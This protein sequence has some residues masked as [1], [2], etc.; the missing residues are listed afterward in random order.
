MNWTSLS[1]ILKR[2]LLKDQKT[3]LTLKED[4]RKGGYYPLPP[5]MGLKQGSAVRRIS[6]ERLQDEIRHRYLDRDPQVKIKGNFIL[7]AQRPAILDVYCG[8][9]HFRAEGD[10]PDRAT[11]EGLTKESILKQLQ[12]T[13]DTPFVFDAA[14]IDP[15]EGLFLPVSSLN[16][17]RR[18]ALAGLQ[19]EIIAS[20]RRDTISAPVR[21]TAGE[22]TENLTIKDN[23]DRKPRRHVLLSDPSLLAFVLSFDDVD[24]ICLDTVYYLDHQER[25]PAGDIMAVK[26]AG[27]ECM[28]VMPWIWREKTQR[29][30]QKIFP[31]Q[32]TAL[33]D[34]YLIRLADQIPFC[35]EKA[36]RD[37]VILAADSS[38]YTW[39]TGAVRELSQLGLAEFTM[40]MELNHHEL[41]GLADKRSELVVYG[42]QKIM[43]T[44]QC[45]KKNTTACDGNP[46]W[47]YLQDRTG[48][49]TR[50]ATHCGICMNTVYNSEP[51]CLYDLSEK[52]KIFEQ[53]G[54]VRYDFTTETKQQA[55]MILKGEERPL[56]YTRGHF[57]RGV[58]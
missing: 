45:L 46:S 48:R 49:K 33:S 44:E 3:L 7:R 40:S 52:E 35:S 11:G 9:A 5:A 30:F 10:V 43:I 56:H 31:E 57:Y 21:E 54:A 28:L 47:I 41:A 6:S 39:N 16:R 12:K 26:E 4:V 32:V 19:G 22:K 51:L 24:R 36:K 8:S 42:Y 55:G 17:I 23:D 25:T 38:V 20:G 50:I 1:M 18:E 37:N 58:E 2:I 53:I 15:E 13:K 14:D 34:G 29:L 27:K